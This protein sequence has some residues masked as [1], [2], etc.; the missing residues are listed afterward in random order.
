ML[1]H[2]VKPFVKGI[3]RMEQAEIKRPWGGYSILKKSESHWVKKLFIHQDARTSLQTHAFRD[4]IWFV[5]S[6]EI[7][8]QIGRKISKAKSGDVLYIPKKKS[9]G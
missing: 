8:A 9:I 1:S 5:L 6:G 4:E 3:D 2:H 7:Y